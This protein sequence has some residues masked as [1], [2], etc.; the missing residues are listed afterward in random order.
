MTICRKVW[1]WMVAGLQSGNGNT[2]FVPP[3]CHPES[4][5]VDALGLFPQ[6]RLSFKPSVLAAGHGVQ[7]GH[8]PGTA[9][10]PL[11]QK[12]CEHPTCQWPGDS[13]AGRQRHHQEQQWLLVIIHLSFF[14]RLFAALNEAFDTVW[15]A[16]KRGRMPTLTWNSFAFFKSAD[17]YVWVSWNFHNTVNEKEDINIKCPFH[18]GRQDADTWIQFVHLSLSL[19]NLEGI[20]D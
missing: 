11:L 2:E 10:E 20:K 8:K 18:K 12:G 1:A 14:F 17:F 6:L 4:P 13:A 16:G 15:K 3:W 5:Q 7:A 19:T 9:H